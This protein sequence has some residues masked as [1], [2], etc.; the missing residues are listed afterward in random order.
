MCILQSMRISRTSACPLVFMEHYVVLSQQLIQKPAYVYRR[1]ALSQETGLPAMPSD[2]QLA[3]WLL[4]CLALLVFR[5]AT[6]LNAQS[7]I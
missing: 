3:K 4:R 2:R 5:H 6:V 7:D 1:C